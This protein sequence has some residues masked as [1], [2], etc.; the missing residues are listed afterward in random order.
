[1]ALSRLRHRWRAPGGYREF[2]AI[3]LPLILS[4][5][6]WS[7]QNFVDRV[8][9]TWYSTESLAAAMPAGMSSFLILSLFLGVAAYV[10]TFVA[11]YVGARQPG[12]VGPAVWQGIYLAVLGGGIALAPAALATPLFDLIG[13]S[14]PVRLQ[15]ATYFRILCYGIGPNI[16]A[17]AAACFFSGRGRTW[18]V[19]AVSLVA[20]A[21]NIVADYLLIFGA[22]GFPELG[23]RGAGWATD[24]AQGVA[25]AAFLTL[26]LLP[27]YRKEFNSLSGWRPD[28][29]LFRRLLRY[30]G[31][32]GLNFMLDITAFTLFMLIVGRLGTIQLA[33]TNLAF[34]INHLAFM[35]IVGCGMAISIMVGQRL[36]RDT[37]EEA[38][39]STWSGF[40]IAITYMALMSLGYLLVP[41]WFLTPFGLRSQGVEFQQARAIAIHLLRIVALYCMFDA[42][43]MIFTAALKGAGDTRYIM[44]MSV[45]LGWCIMVIPAVVALRY[46]DPSIYL[47]WAFVCAY[48]IT[49]GLV[50]YA[51]FR[52]GRWKT[53]RVI[54]TPPVVLPEDVPVETDAYL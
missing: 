15:E 10:N 16:L 50:F 13:H 39:Y 29:R 49:A 27:R 31:P 47:L 9:L 42:F 20:I 33:A 34:N 37:P 52:T 32:N 8:F 17:T 41:D 45:V 53:M 19:L 43:Y 44:G 22:L 3:A 51:R 28:A 26:F 4:T 35:P 11:Q 5:A 24:L 6:S 36:G 38:E 23:I 12:R 7:V 14:E 25:A 18:V 1:M 48:I 46:F 40:H 30:G 54:E 21:V 2:L